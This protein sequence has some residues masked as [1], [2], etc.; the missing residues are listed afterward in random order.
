MI[1][2][3]VMFTTRYS[4]DPGEQKLLDLTFEV[5]R[6]GNC[7]HPGQDT[8]ARWLNRSTRQVQRYLTHLRELQLIFWK[9]RGKKLTNAYYV[10]G[11][12][13]RVLTKGRRIP[14]A[15]TEHKKEAPV[16]REEAKRL[17]AGILASL[18]PGG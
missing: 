18:A 13:W 12:L 5:C 8:L 6:R 17:L 2:L 14:G 11:A 16:G 10:G 4:L 9:R 15:V 7:F 3:P 1:Q